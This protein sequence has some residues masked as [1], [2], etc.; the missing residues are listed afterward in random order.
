MPRQKNP[1]TEPEPVDVSDIP[2]DNP[3]SEELAT[4]IERAAQLLDDKAEI[5]AQLQ[6]AR[7]LASLLV[8]NGSGSR[9]QVAW[10]RTRLPRK[11]RREQ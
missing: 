4:L 8:E 6:S 11:K 9:E 1:D 3:G 7:Q 10:V 5:L 2:E